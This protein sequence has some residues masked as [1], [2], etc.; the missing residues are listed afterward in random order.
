[1]KKYAKVLSTVCAFLFMLGLAGCPNYADQI[2]AV[3]KKN[4]ELLNKLEQLEAELAEQKAQDDFENFKAA[5]TAY[6]KF[7]ADNSKVV[8]GQTY[9]NEYDYGYY[10]GTETFVITEDGKVTYKNNDVVDWEGSLVGAE[11]P[12]GYKGIILYTKL[13][14]HVNYGAECYPDYDEDKWEGSVVDAN[15]YGAITHKNCYSAFYVTDDNDVSGKKLSMAS[16]VWHP[17]NEPNGYTTCAKTPEKAKELFSICGY[18]S[19]CNGSATHFS[20]A[21]NIPG[22]MFGTFTLAD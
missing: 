7:V 5:S 2:D 3:Q 12:A 16:A 8:L 19:T 9:K 4:Q 13:D 22:I 10:A 14:K 20:R 11:I 17:K 6:A 21:A 1:M 18:D 15:N